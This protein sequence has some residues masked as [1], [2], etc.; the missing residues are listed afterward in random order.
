MQTLKN[1]QQQFLAAL[2]NPATQKDF[3]AMIDENEK[4]QKAQRLAIYRD[5][6]QES[7]ITT[8]LTTFSVCDQ[9]IGRE[10]F[11]G[12][13]KLY[14]QQTPALSPDLG[15]YGDSFS[16]FIANFTAAKSVPYLADMAKWEWLYWQALQ[17]PR[18]TSLTV[19]AMLKI[20]EARQHAIRFRL[21][22]N[23][24]LFYSQ[25]PVI[26]IWRWHQEQ[27][28]GSSN[29]NWNLQNNYH[30][31]IR[32]DRYPTVFDLTR[33]QWHLLQKLVMQT[34]LGNLM[35]DELTLLPEFMR[36]GWLGEIILE[37]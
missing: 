5:S 29:F 14:L 33:E 1:L 12:L 26:A 10:A 11:R 20:P 24:H 19:A 17:G 36:Q 37:A 18:S 16:E 22:F 4:L 28:A 31:L 35:K 23:T 27:C 25:Y 32:S 21:P 30:L 9:L 2:K 34:K 8:L 3:F 7:L 6:I 15:Q 13:A